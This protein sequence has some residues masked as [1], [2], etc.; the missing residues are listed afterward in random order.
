MN[1]DESK[2]KMKT[3][4]FSNLL[5]RHPDDELA[6]VLPGG[7]SI[8]SHAHVTEVGRTEKTFLDCGGKLRRTAFCSLQIWVADDEEHR[9]TAGKLASI[10]EKAA[11]L[12]GQDDLEI[13]IECQKDSIALFSVKESSSS[14]GVLAFVLEAKQ[15]ACLAMDVCLPKEESSECCSGSG[16]C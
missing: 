5:D 16:C 9:L 15:T 13:Q 7:N 1:P 3:S 6:F 12:L 10:F 11:G 2:F 8:P 14:E 4:E